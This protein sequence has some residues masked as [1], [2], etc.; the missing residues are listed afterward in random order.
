MSSLKDQSSPENQNGAYT[1]RLVERAGGVLADQL[2]KPLSPGL[3][4]V[5]T[6]IGHLADI[7][8]RA[9]AVLGGA[10][11]VAAEDTRR[12]RVLLSH[13]GLS[14]EMI[15]YHDHNG[16][17]MMPRIVEMIESGRAV[18]LIS[19]A[20]TPLISDPG[21][22]LARSVRAAG[23]PVEVVPGASAVMAGLSL[24]GLPTDRFLFEG[25]LPPKSEARLR[26]LNSLKDLPA[27]LVFFET[28]KRVKPVLKAMLEV[29]GNREVALCRELTKLHEEVISGP[30]EAVFAGLE[31]RSLKGELVIVVGPPAACAVD[32]EAIVE[33]LKTHLGA[34]ASLKDSVSLVCGALQLP[35]GRVYGLALAL[36]KEGEA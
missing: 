21:Y 13:F 29:L 32:D 25:F 26:Q 23:M 17:H 5:A 27:T 20:G 19:D 18:A 15:S 28:V 22:K 9:L 2:S 14:P 24:S 10:A 31:D 33:L 34:G 11:V 8:L 6:P 35:R 4:L 1:G 3:Y 7:T 16:A 30:I 36:K 12:S